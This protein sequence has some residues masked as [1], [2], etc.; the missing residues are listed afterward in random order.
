MASFTIPEKTEMLLKKHFGKSTTNEN[1]RFYEEIPRDA[2]KEVIAQRQLWSSTIPNVAPP[3]LIGLGDSDLDDNGYKLAGSVVGKTSN[4]GLIKRFIKVPFSMI[5]GSNGE[6]YET[7]FYTKSHPN[8]NAN[9]TPASGYGADVSVNY[10]S[11]DVIPF[12]FDTSGSYLYK[13]YRSNGV[14]INFGHGEWVIDVPTGT[15]MFHDYPAVSSE[16]SFTNPPLL[17]F[18]KYVGNKGLDAFAQSIVVGTTIFDSGINGSVGDDLAALQVSTQPLTN[19]NSGL[20]TDA[21]QFGNN[22][23]GAFR[24]CVEGGVASSLVVQKRTFSGW[25]TVHRLAQ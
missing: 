1:R 12:N 25:Q 23:I 4:S 6:S 10:P 18:Y 13:L 7:T 2:S 5:T 24:I 14:E 17:S 21:I 11:S 3:E 9:G 8:N 22:T 20:F 19:I 15:I 16:V